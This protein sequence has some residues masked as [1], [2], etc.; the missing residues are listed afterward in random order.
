[1]IIIDDENDDDDDDDDDDNNNEMGL[2][3][4]QNS[5]LR[6]NNESPTDEA[7]SPLFWILIKKESS[8]WINK[9]INKSDNSEP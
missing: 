5:K 8:K 7:F 2:R 3:L 9:I 6:V 1:M 4:K